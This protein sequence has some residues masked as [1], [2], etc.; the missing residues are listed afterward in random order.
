MKSLDK[1]S[2]EYQ[3]LYSQQLACKI[4]LNSCF[5]KDTDIL[6]LDGIKKVKDVVI[7]EYVYSINKDTKQVELKRVT[8]TQK[9]MFNGNL[10]G[11][12]KY[13]Y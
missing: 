1:K 5:H 11:Y 10:M 4:I 3:F 9:F 12:Q 8:D 2:D 6:T 13:K 7:G